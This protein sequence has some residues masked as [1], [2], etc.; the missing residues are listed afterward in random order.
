MEK[1]NDI[2][3]Y[4]LDKAIKT[5]RMYAMKKIRENGY[6]ITTDQWLIIKSI[7]E[8]PKITQQE[9][10]RNVFKD[11]ASVTRIIELMVKSNYLNRKVDSNDRR[12]SVLSVT[13]E[14]KDIIEKVQSIILEN[15][16][17]AL[18]SISK[19]DLNT[20]DIILQKIIKNCS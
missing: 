5:Y 15:R 6:K 19:E 11:N 12:K 2:I 14:G 1:L 17:E 13:K 8:N 20:M 4:N 3:F 9:L 10:A 18:E 7:L 16:K